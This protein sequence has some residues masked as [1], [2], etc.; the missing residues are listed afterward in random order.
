M[1]VWVEGEGQGQGEERNI[2]W[3]PVQDFLKFLW[4]FF[5]EIIF[6]KNLG[7]FCGILGDPLGFL[8]IL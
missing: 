6:G 3:I 8:W 5:D 4:G 7:F 2:V 1:W